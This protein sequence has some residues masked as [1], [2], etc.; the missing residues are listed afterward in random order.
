MAFYRYSLTESRKYKR[1]HYKNKH[2]ECTYEALNETIAEYQLR[3][4]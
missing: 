2:I 4:K 1:K 3:A